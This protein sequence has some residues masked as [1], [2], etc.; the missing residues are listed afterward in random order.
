MPLP[1]TDRTQ[2]AQMMQLDAESPHMAAA[3]VSVPGPI[4]VLAAAG[5]LHAAPAMPVCGVRSGRAPLVMCP[6]LLQHTHARSTCQSRANSLAQPQR[7][8]PMSGDSGSMSPRHVSLKP[9]DVDGSASRDRKTS[10]SS[11]VTFSARL[12]RGSMLASP[13]RLAVC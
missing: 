2:P 9:S 10:G 1:G 8:V 4:L 12:S 3:P 6:P 11:T 5:T 13:E 7:S